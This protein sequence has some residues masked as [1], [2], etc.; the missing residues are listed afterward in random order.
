MNDSGTGLLDL[1]HW[2]ERLCEIEYDVFNAAALSAARRSKQKRDAVYVV[3]HSDAL[4]ESNTI[5]GPIRQTGDVQVAILLAIRNRRSA[6]GDEGVDE[7]FAVRAAIHD[8]LLGWEPP[9]AIAPV[10]RVGGRLMEFEDD[11]TIWW[12]DTW[13]TQILVYRTTTDIK[14]KEKT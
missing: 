4:Q 13:K 12:Q 3:P 9:D 10:S 5:S 8:W 14:G 1:R 7:V 11:G 6:R 2:V